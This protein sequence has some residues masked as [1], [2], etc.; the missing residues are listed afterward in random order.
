MLKHRTVVIKIVC[1]FSRAVNK[2]DL[3]IAS[4]KEF[5]HGTFHS[6]KKDYLKDAEKLSLA[7]GDLYILRI[8]LIHLEHKLFN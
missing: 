7:V 3:G 2:R 1:V 8:G 6:E 4:S 5:R